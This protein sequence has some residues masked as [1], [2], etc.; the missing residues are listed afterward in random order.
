VIYTD[1]D[2]DPRIGQ[3]GPKNN[4]GEKSR[5]CVNS[6][7]FKQKIQQGENKKRM[8]QKGL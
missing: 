4:P 2:R 5:F 7:S 6:I 1:T 3:E 8:N